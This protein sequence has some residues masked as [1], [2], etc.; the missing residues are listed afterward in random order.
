MDDAVCLLAL[1]GTVLQCNLSMAHLLAVQPSAVVGKKCYEL[2]HGTGTFFERCPYREM[3]R[4]GRRECFELPQGDAW[5]EVTADPL[6]SDTGEIT[7]AVHIVRDVTRRKQAEEALQES[8]RR[9]GLVHDHVADLL[10]TLD[11]EQD[12]R[13]RI[14][15]ANPRFLEATGLTIDQ[16]LGSYI[17]DVVPQPSLDLALEHFRTA[18]R[19]NRTVSWDATTIYSTGQRTGHVSVTPVPDAGGRCAHLIVTVHDVT[20]RV[21][22]EQALRDHT[23]QLASLNAL[24][25]DLTS[26]S[27]NEDLGVLLAERLRAVTG[28]PA[29]SFSD[30]DPES[31]ALVIRHVALRPGAAQAAAAP[32][33]GR[34]VGA[35]SPV[36]DEV[37]AQLAG[38]GS[39]VLLTLD[40][41][42]SGRSVPAA[43]REVAEQLGTDESL[44]LTYVVDGELFGTSHIAVEESGP[45]PSDQLLES[46]AHVAGVSLRRRRVER[47]LRQMNAYHRSLLE[48]S[49]DP[50]VTIGS[51]GFIT[52]VNEA[53]V[54]VTGRKRDELIGSDFADCF[55]DPGRARAGL[56]QAFREDAVRDYPLAIRHRDGHVTDVLYNASTYRD[57]EGRVA[58]VFAAAR[59]IGA[60]RRAEE[61]IREVNADLE[62]RV[63][64]RTRELTATNRDLQEFMYSLAHDLRSPLR[65]VDG[66]SFAVLEDYGDVIAEE[67]QDDLH[68]VRAAAQQ[69]GILIDALLSLSQLGGRRIEMRTVDLSAI[70]RS[71][72]DGL[73]VSEP[74]RTVD[75]VIE[76]GLSA[77]GDEALIT[78]ILESLLGNAWKF[79]SQRPVAHIEF[80]TAER[81]GLRV[82]FVRDDG[83]G[84][85]P[86]FADKLFTPFQRLHTAEEFTGAGT[87]LATVARILERLGGM[88]WA[89]GEVGQGATFSFSLTGDNTAEAGDPG[90]GDPPAGA[91]A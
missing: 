41:A 61:E 2:M 4:T 25:L 15:A 47:E 67:G 7:G 12:G 30:Y 77:A 1:D 62:R 14:A 84:F 91:G 90:G 69:M 88:W 26:M 70:A 27:A 81:D 35:R 18:I 21:Q 34:L 57:A 38:T 33:L 76:D 71:V 68:R 54:A 73:R 55:V 6:F 40:Q 13:F 36:S 5:Y 10:C 9:L 11:V 60:L 80:A 78:V 45:T 89:E 17:D 28:A 8:E 75:V 37:H 3:L 31:R 29:V 85:D 86:A 22:A 79:T 52:D 66:F 42:V 51:A 59:D 87:G 58:G 39:P 48:A 32:L 44:L 24:A 82:F 43:G 23:A 83:A 74:G 63:D 56:E 49:L 64:E 46:F 72:V 19:E 65:A 53:V 20:A 50:L 16:V